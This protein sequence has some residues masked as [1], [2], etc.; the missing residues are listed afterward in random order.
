MIFSKIDVLDVV[1]NTCS[2]SAI[3]DLFMLFRVP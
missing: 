3:S 1:T 2:G